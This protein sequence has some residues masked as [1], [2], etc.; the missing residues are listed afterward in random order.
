MD[1]FLSELLTEEYTG[2]DARPKK[3]VPVI[4]AVRTARAGELQILR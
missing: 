2:I 3:P 4:T 1:P